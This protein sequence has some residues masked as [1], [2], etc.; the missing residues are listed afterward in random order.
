[1]VSKQILMPTL[2]SGGWDVEF[3]NLKHG[4]Y[5]EEHG[6]VTW[7]GMDMSKV[8]V[9]RKITEIDPTA[10]DVWGLTNNFSQHR[11]VTCMVIKHLTKGG[12]PIVV[13]GSDC[14]AEPQTYFKAGAAAVVTDKSGGSNCKILDYIIGRG[15]SDDLSGVI[16]ANGEIGTKWS[17]PLGA[18]EWPLPSLDTVHQ[19]LGQEYW[20]KPFPEELLPVGAVIPDNGCDRKCD[21]CQTP[22]YRLG[23]KSMT[24][25]RTLQWVEAQKEVGARSV[26]FTSDQF[27]ARVLWENGREQV[28]E[29]MKGVREIGLPH[30]WPNGLELRKA[31]LGRGFN[32]EDSDLTPDEELINALW[33]W[34]GKVGCFHAYIPGERPLIGRE[35]YAKLLPWQQHCELM[36]SVVR[37]G[38]AAI[39][40]GVII[41]FPDESHESLQTLEQALLELFDDLQ[42][43]NPALSFQVS[44]FGL[45][46]IPGT[47]QG[48]SYRKSGLLRFDDPVLYG[49]FYTPSMDTH[50]LRYQEI[51][52]WMHRLLAIRSEGVQLAQNP[53]FGLQGTEK[54]SCELTTP[55]S[56]AGQATHSWA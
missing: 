36:R 7:D 42:Q 24:P 23:Y 5:E 14:V 35:N 12:R 22:T 33:G 46:P 41:G 18:E 52:E 25:S 4:D 55:Q 29:I 40:Y 49:G 45:L 28:L 15:S 47:P 13:G 19:C 8:Y 53:H 10:Y 32:H 48:N 6:R 34:D 2:Q 16:F 51:A 20:R 21:F 38:V 50:H 26:L 31:T 43:V 39:N 9:G 54:V 3:I 30:H 1:M 17:R 11:E 27:L 56:D 44:C 37:S